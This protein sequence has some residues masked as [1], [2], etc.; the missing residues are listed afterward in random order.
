MGSQ[1]GDLILT[2]LEKHFGSN[3]KTVAQKLLYGPKP[4][5]L[6][7][8]NIDL[9]LVQ[10]KEAL[11]IL[12]KHNLG[13]FK[14]SKNGSTAEYKLN[15]HNILQILSYSKYLQL[16]QSKYGDLARDIVNA[17][18]IHGY[19]SLSHIIL[20]IAKQNSTDLHAINL[21]HL[22]DMCMKLVH[23]EYLVRHCDI[24]SLP[25]DQL[26]PNITVEESEKSME[27]KI[28]MKLL[29]ECLEHK[30]NSLLVD[31]VIFG[32]DLSRFDQD[33]R[34]EILLGAI[35]QRFSSDA[36]LVFSELLSET[37]S[38]SYYG[39]PESTSVNI[40]LLQDKVKKKYKQ[41]HNAEQ[42]IKILGDPTCGWIQN[43]P[44]ISN[45]VVIRFNHI[46]HILATTLIETII[47]I[48]YGLKAARIFRIIRTKKFVEQNQIQRLAMIPDKE[49]KTLTYNL[50]HDNFVMIQELRKPGA[51]QGPT[52]TYFL[53]HVNIRL[54]LDVTLNYCYKSI[55]NAYMRIH[56][57]TT[58]H[59]SLVDKYLH[60]ENLRRSVNTEQ[61]GSEEI[62]EAL[63]QLMCP[64]EKEQVSN[65]NKMI[66][67][68]ETS[69][70]NTNE[71]LFLLNL[72]K[73]HLNQ[74][75]K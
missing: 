17:F 2:I 21:T 8:H 32:L 36:R 29:Y 46:I 67:Q 12:I 50:L 23:D 10:V 45:S 65:V 20:R 58:Q 15:Y 56:H 7:F 51:T 3:V 22:R 71:S 37:V 70:L 47:H 63:D 52:K 41:D 35:E 62:L 24:S 49:A 44:D 19:S 31:C 57:E 1:C 5:K 54:V 27:P 48:K 60:I 13:L 66:H 64:S 42:W 6:I 73:H 28:D 26:V 38:S 53:F 75:I 69:I 30:D 14:R 68:L 74:D 33:Y 34:D 72:F 43:S 55:A 39:S 4:L 25:D 18:M 40:N 59:Q 61:E 11:H 9:K 16:I